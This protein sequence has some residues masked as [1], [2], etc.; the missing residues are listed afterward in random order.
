MSTNCRGYYI[1][2][3]RHEPRTFVE[4]VSLISALGDRTERE[5]LRFPGGGPRLVLSPLGV[6]E[7]DAAGD[8]RVRTLHEGVTGDQAV[9]ATGFDLGLDG[10]PPA[11]PAPTDDELTVLRERVDVHGTL[12]A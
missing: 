11:T 3:P 6:F 7:F 2:M 5:R 9:A 10:D 4:R 12:R 8:L 1:V